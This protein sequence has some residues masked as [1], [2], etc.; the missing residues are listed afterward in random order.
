MV[1]KIRILRLKQPISDKKK[2]YDSEYRE[3]PMQKAKTHLKSIIIPK[4][5]K[6][7]FVKNIYT[8]SKTQYKK[9][10]KV[11]NT[12]HLLQ[13]TKKLFQITEHRHF[14]TT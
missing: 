7:K 10:T 12:S 1:S 8:N 11:T 14:Y 9:K 4:H 5:L 6:A 3:A 2:L 13:N